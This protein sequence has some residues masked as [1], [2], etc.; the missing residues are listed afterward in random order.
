[1]S[2]IM[3][4]NNLIDIL[5]TVRE[6]HPDCEIYIAEN[7]I[8]ADAVVPFIRP[9]V[10]EDFLYE[11]NMQNLPVYMQSDFTTGLIIGRYP[12][13]EETKIQEPT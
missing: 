11:S 8:S 7:G 13:Y 3:N 1:M 10:P 2:I 5:T 6:N 12:V 4:I 9:S